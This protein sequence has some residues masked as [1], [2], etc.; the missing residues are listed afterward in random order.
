MTAGL[1]H[2]EV[3]ASLTGAR[4]C[5][6][7]SAFGRFRFDL[8]FCFRGFGFRRGARGVFGGLGVW[9]DLP[10]ERQR[11]LVA[12]V[13]LTAVGEVLLEHAFSPRQIAGGNTGARFKIK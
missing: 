3:G 10:I 13:L 8:G 9:K 11:F 7:F 2:D 12:A 4:R 5:E 1:D 6:N